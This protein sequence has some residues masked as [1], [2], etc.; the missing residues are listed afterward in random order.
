[1]MPGIER[2][3]ARVDDLASRTDVLADRRDPAGCYGKA[4][5]PQCGAQA[6]DDEGVAD[7]EVMHGAA[8]GG[9]RGDGTPSSAVRAQRRRAVLAL[10]AATS[11][12]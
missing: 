6:V 1:M 4:A 9:R 10:P 5:G 8:P 11:W 2:E 12:H 3:A 7:H